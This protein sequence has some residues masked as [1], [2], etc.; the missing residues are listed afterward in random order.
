MYQRARHLSRD[1]GNVNLEK[2][3]QE[4]ERYWRALAVRSVEQIEVVLRASFV[5][6]HEMLFL[7]SWL[8][9]W[10]CHSLLIEEARRLGSSEPE[11][12]GDGDAQYR[13]SL[14]RA[15]RWRFR[16]DLAYVIREC[17][18]LF[19]YGR[20]PNY[21]YQP[22][23]F[24]TSLRTLVE[25][26][27]IWILNLPRGHDIRGL[28]REIGRVGGRE[29][30][31]FAAGH[32][33]HVL[34]IYIAGQFYCDLEIQV[35]D[36]GGVEKSIFDGW[37][38]QEVLA[39]R[40]AWRPGELKRKEFRKAF[41]IA[42]LLHD[43]GIL[44]FPDWAPNAEDLGEIDHV[45]ARNLR[46][47]R[48]VL[49]HSAGELLRVCDR[50][51][52]GEGYYDPTEEPRLAAWIADCVERGT[53]DHCLLGAWYL[54]RICHNVDEL[55]SDT[56]LQAVRA[57]LLHGVVTQPIEVDRDPAAAL[58]VMCDE[59]FMWNHQH[60]LPAVDETG[61]SFQSIAVDVRPQTTLIDYVKFE[62]LI[63]PPRG[64]GPLY[65][66]LEVAGRRRAWP[67]LEMRLKDPDYL[68]TPVYFIWLMMAQNLGRIVRSEYGW[69]PL[70]KLWSKIP[71]RLDLCELN[72]HS[73]L[74]EAA[75]RA[76]MSLRPS[77][78][79]WL[80][81]EHRFGRGKD[82]EEPFGKVIEAINALEPNGLGASGEPSERARW[83]WV[84]I[85]PLRSFH[86][87]D[88]IFCFRELGEI[89]ERVLR[90]EELI[91]QESPISRVP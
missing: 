73:L 81:N 55:S 18:R 82:G 13:I 72:N 31:Y 27:A 38:L 56:V 47:V 24:S 91:F 52:R 61:R 78:E 34:E 85:G 3:F 39:S 53:P 29:D 16:R 67:L 54:H 86:Q 17:L 2:R 88:I 4:H 14:S 84:K 37:T 9:L 59:V 66:R 1:K 62:N 15:Q 90:D 33:Q 41:S 50:E 71:G 8:R 77:L 51:L 11:A 30:Y 57:V 28:L 46:S 49:D 44:L 23:V 40:S 22:M 36:A 35:Q 89:I 70:I 48:D 76:S 20:E 43:I 5:K 58:L 45:L 21:I 25:H 26:H 80:S 75:N 69:A 19:R 65:G 32:L 60:G 63:L 12:Q 7:P 74:E 68:E 87:K 64:D 42:A 10:F 79:R 83:E 6:C